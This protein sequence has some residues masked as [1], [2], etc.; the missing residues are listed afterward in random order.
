MYLRG[1]HSRAERHEQEEASDISHHGGAPLGGDPYMVWRMYSGKKTRLL[2][3]PAAGNPPG[4]PLLILAEDLRVAQ[5]GAE[6]AEQDAVQ[7]RLGLRQAV[8]DPEPLLPTNDQAVL[9]QV[10]QVP[11]DGRLGDA[12]RL[13]EMAHAYLV[14]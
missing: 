12:K 10:R 13:E 8:V 11:G 4:Q 6:A 5:A 7:P 14:P 3:V 2:T 1:E 9:S